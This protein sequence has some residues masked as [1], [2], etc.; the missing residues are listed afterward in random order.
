M[1]AT[2]QFSLRRIAPVLWVIAL[3]ALGLLAF[4][5]AST[6]IS[7]RA[8]LLLIGAIWLTALWFGWRWKPARI[9]FC[10]LALIPVALLA[11]TWPVH[12]SPE[13]M[14]DAYVRSLRTYEGC[15]YFWGGESR[16]GIDCSGLIRRA[17]IDACFQQGLARIDLGLLQRGFS[18]WWHDVSAEAMGQEYAG[19]TSFQRAAPSLQTLDHSGL[20]PGAIAVTQSGRHVM[21]Y[22]GDATWIEADPG[23]G[24]VVV[25]H[26]PTHQNPW[27]KVPMR[28]MEWTSLQKPSAPSA[29][30]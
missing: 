15:E 7:R 16:S 25:L 2:T 19:L 12:T 4:Q 22:V 6:G 23:E 20:A 8:L 18:L 24:K 10:S 21:A 3:L 13:T 27:L 1:Q 5:P 14:R 17:M 26:A 29:A 28:I 30:E 9:C 11:R